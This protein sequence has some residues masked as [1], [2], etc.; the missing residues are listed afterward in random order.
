MMW[1]K[2]GRIFNPSEHAFDNTFVGFSQSPQTLVFDDFV[3]VYF[4]MRKKD[5]ESKFVSHIQYADFS[6]NMDKVLRISNH[7]VFGPGKKGCFDEHGVFPINIVR[8]AQKIMA[9]TNGWTRRVSVSVDTGI[10]YAE[11]HDGGETF[12]RIG[13]GPVLSSTP[14]EPLLVGD[15]FVRY[16]EGQFHMWYIFG[17]GWKKYGEFSQP[18]R[19]YKIA[20]ATSRNGIDWIKEDGKCIIPDR[21]NADECQALPTV[22]KIDARYHMIFCYRSSYDFRKNPENAYRLGYAFSDDLKTWQRDDSLAGLDISPNEWD[23]EMQCY[24]HLFEVDNR[25]Y[26]LYNGNEFGKNGF[27]AALLIKS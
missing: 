26:L 2:L 18:D 4:S 13:D 10:G 11:S 3:R 22:I 25:V 24:P 1:K 21:M 8:H 19:I 5:I 6:K 12:V 9:Y 17:L 27:G 23:S 16:F 14:N 7:P 15:A 20:H